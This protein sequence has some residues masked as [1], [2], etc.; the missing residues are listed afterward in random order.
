MKRSVAANVRFEPKADVSVLSSQARNDE[1]WS[2]VR[3][4]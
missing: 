4:R 2:D 1:L 3:R